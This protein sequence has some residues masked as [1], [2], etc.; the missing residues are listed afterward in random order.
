[1]EVQAEAEVGGS[2]D[3]RPHPPDEEPQRGRICI[4]DR[5]VI[6]PHRSFGSVQNDTGD[7]ARI[8]HVGCSENKRF[9][10]DTLDL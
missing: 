6:S 4:G 10:S 9:A 5:K 1:M 2:V 7:K 3:V 8:S